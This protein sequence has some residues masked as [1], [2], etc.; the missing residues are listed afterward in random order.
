MA[1]D[2]LNFS[3]FIPFAKTVPAVIIAN[4]GMCV[5]GSEAGKPSI[6]MGAVMCEL[7]SSW[8]VA[9]CLILQINCE[10]KTSE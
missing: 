9:V 6:L 10:S 4:L 3:S 2:V 1:Q 7:F 5:N 8:E